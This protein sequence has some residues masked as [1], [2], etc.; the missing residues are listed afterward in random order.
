M[1]ENDLMVT[2][3]VITKRLTPDGEVIINC[4]TE[5]EPEYLEILGLLEF[6]KPPECWGC[7][8]SDE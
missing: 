2:S 4:R 6:V 7:G 8:S 5:G 3:L 1:N